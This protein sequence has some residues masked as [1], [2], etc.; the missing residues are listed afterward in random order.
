MPRKEMKWNHHNTSS[1]TL[2]SERKSKKEQVGLIGNNYQDGKFNMT[3]LI[4]TLIINGLNTQL[5]GRD[6]QSGFK[7]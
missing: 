3:V 7:K 5:E 2:N 6:C 4:I 1:I